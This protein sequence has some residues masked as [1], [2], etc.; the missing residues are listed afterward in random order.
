LL[1][2]E[3]GV[4]IMRL[5]LLSAE[6]ALDGKDITEW[7]KVRKNALRREISF[8]SKIGFVKPKNF[9]K[10]IHKTAAKKKK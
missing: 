7:S 1:G 10:E 8:F 6:M 2:T 4:K 3:K 5:L 9:T